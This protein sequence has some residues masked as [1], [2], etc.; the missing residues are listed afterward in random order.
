M[1]FS[2]IERVI[3]RI[4]E[5]KARFNINSGISIKTDLQEKNVES[6]ESILK[7]AMSKLKQYEDKNVNLVE[8]G[9]GYEKVREV[10]E[11]AS[12]A[13]GVDKA[14][15]LA[16]AKA[17]SNFNQKA[18]SPKGAIGVMQLMPYTAESLGVNPYDLE[19]NILGGAFY[20]KSL[21]DRFDGD[22]VKA[23]AAYNAGPANVEKY[24]GIPPFEETKNYVQRV[25]N[26]YRFYKNFF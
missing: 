9:R 22:L 19:D 8:N 17:E 2:N 16:V 15:I 10:I 25:L 4:E 26:Y 21:L 11:K 5:I 18:I 20:L 23:L 7:N 24:K 3:S 12:E 6:F 1:D 14:L 13:L